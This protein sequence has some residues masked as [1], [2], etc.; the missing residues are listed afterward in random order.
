MIED[1][2]NIFSVLDRPDILSFVFYPRKDN[3]QSP[4]GA[5]NVSFK[6]PDSINLGGRF[7]L[8]NKQG[9]LFL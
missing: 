6:M 4:S 3:S 8:A 7:Y 2:L 1:D 5:Q 9:T